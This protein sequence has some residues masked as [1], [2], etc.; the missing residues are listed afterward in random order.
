MIDPCGRAPCV[1]RTR[2]GRVGSFDRSAEADAAAGE[3]IAAAGGRARSFVV[4][5][6]DAAQVAD[7]LAKFEAA[8]GWDR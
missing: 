2:R 1:T 5:I 8:A 7:A 3:S 4:D 6:A